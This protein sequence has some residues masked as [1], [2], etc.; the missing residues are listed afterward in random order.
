[1]NPKRHRVDP[2]LIHQRALVLRYTGEL[3]KE[4]VPVHFFSRQVLGALAVYKDKGAVHHEL[5]LDKD[6]LKAVDDPFFLLGRGALCINDLDR[7]AELL[8]DRLKQ[9]VEQAITEVGFGDHGVY[10]VILG[11]PCA[12]AVGA[13]SEQLRPEW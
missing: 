2:A 1:M 3:V 11:D 5:V 4:P 9:L 13:A 7:T 6:R 10:F 8:E 12:S